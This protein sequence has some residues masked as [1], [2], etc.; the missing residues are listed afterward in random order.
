MERLFL[1]DQEEFH[2]GSGK[3]LPRLYA[4]VHILFTEAFLEAEM[5]G[6]KSQNFVDELEFLN[7]TYGVDVAM[8][9]DETPT[10]DRER[11]EKILDLLIERKLDLELLMGN[12][13]G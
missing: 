9:A 12:P 13:C 8:I 7:K 5:E 3:F 6:A 11:W 4:E 2:S 1:Q 10:F